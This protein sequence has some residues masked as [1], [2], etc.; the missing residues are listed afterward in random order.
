MSRNFGIGQRDMSRAGNLALDRSRQNKAVSYSTAATQGARWDSF[1][2][3]AKE[4]GVKKMENVT[5]DFVIEYGKYLALDVNSEKMAAATAQNYVSAVNSVMSIATKGSWISVSPTRDCGIKN[6]SSIRTDAPAAI[7]RNTFEKSLQLVRE[8]V[9]ERAASVV[10]LARD[11]GLRSKEASLLN[12]RSALDQAERYGYIK[13]SDG[14]KG[15]LDR[16]I[17]ITDPQKIETLSRAEQA[18]GSARSLMPETSNWKTWREGDLRTAREIVQSVTHGGLHDLRS[19]YACER[20]QMITG[21]EA[22]CAGGI[23]HN[24]EIDRSARLEI[25]RELGHQRIDVVSEYIGGRK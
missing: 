11:F 23:I 4:K 22:P 19:A 9:G 6:R 18:Q 16:T 25:A 20:Y 3:W 2:S 14:T 13:I 15:G 17:K 5:A 8:K 7:D 24:K 1:C 21:Q 12:V 10:E